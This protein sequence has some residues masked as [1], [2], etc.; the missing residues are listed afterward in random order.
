MICLMSAG[1]VV[2]LTRIGRFDMSAEARG[3]L[4]PAEEAARARRSRAPPRARA[5]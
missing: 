4:A 2:K 1:E 3:P 5:R